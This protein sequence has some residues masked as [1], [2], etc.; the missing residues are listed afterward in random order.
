MKSTPALALLVLLAGGCGGENERLTKQEYFDRGLEIMQSPEAQE[1]SNLFL[2]LAVGDISSSECVAGTRRF[3]GEIERLVDEIDEVR[4]PE[5]V[6]EI[7]DRLVAAA[8]ETV[9]ALDELADDVDAGNVDCGMDW[10]RRAYGLESTER[11]EA[12]LAELQERGYQ[13]RSR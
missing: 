6:D 4:P 10:N 1:A 8:R 13:F 12:A 3:R 5:E 2:T 7:H 11:A 9:D